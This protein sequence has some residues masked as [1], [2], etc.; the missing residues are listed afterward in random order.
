MSGSARPGSRLWLVDHL[1][2]DPIGHHLG[3]NLALADAAAELGHV[4]VLATHRAFPRDLADGREVHNIFRQDWRTAPPVWMSRNIRLLRV[5][6]H[7]STARFGADLAKI[8]RAVN[9]ED[10]LFAQMLAPRHFIQWLGW[11]SSLPEPPRLAMH[12]GYQPA[13][14]GSAAVRAA[15]DGLSA[16]AR[17][18]VCFITDSEKLVPAFEEILRTK[19]YHLPHVISFE[20]PAPEPRPPEPPLRLLS[21]GNAR[22]EK[23]FREIVQAA[24]LLAPWRAEGQLQFQIQ[25]HHPDHESAG[26]LAAGRPGGSGLVWLEAALPDREYVAELVRADVLLLPYHLDYYASRTSGVFCEARV[27]GKPVVATAGSW[28][29]DRVAREGGGWLVPE[30]DPQALAACLKKIPSEF[31]G[32]AAEA[33]ALAENAR[34]EFCRRAFVRGLLELVE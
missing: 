4:P 30:R 26:L 1:L 19:V 14:F 27:A 17:R 6:E 10:I 25:C 16:A 29:G 8:R 20:I 11:F 22:R 34:R 7:F 33:R 21:L 23:G 9:K 5:L 13:R 2:R 18:R 28:M 32:I 12:L 31:A 3:Y 15:L 24:A